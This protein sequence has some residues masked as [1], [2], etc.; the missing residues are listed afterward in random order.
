MFEQAGT[1]RIT[2]YENKDLQLSFDGNGDI[3]TIYNTGDIIELQNSNCD[4]SNLALSFQ[5]QRAA[6]NDLKYSHTI[7][8]Q[9]IGASDENIEK[10][11]KL[12]TSIYGWIALIEFYNLESKV[13]VNPLRYNNS[14]LDNN[15]SNH[16]NVSL[17]NRVFGAEL[18]NKEFGLWILADGFWNDKGYWIDDEVWND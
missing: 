12:K 4:T 10:I 13:I 18:K 14:T 5:A 2:L 6:G 3:I 17:S 9:E 8:W 11:R 1:Y 15:I 7:T 16:Y